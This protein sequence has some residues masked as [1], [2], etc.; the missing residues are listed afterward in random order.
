[1]PYVLPYLL[2]RGR[3]HLAT[4]HPA[5]AL[6]D[7]RTCDTLM[8]AW[9]FNSPGLALW[10]TDAAQSLIELGRPA[11]AAALIDEQLARAKEPEP[12]FAHYDRG[13]QGPRPPEPA[14]A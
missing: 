1:T 2:A 4:G 13:R 6:Q 3:Y 11:E 8:D 12:A 14:P 5:A 7:L 9:G 10:R